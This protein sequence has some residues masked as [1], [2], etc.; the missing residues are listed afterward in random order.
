MKINELR[1]KSLPELLKLLEHERKSLL[2]LRFQYANRSN[3]NTSLASKSR[4]MVARIMTM[5][6][7]KET[8]KH[9]IREVQ[10]GN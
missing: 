3:N 2:G 7:E 9:E 6:R 4:K 8:K 1:E 10:N 5:M